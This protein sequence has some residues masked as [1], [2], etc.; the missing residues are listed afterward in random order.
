LVIV[1]AVVVVHQDLEPHEEGLALARA[2]D[3]ASG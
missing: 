3:A 1:P 2:S